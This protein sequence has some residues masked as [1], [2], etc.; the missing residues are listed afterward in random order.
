MHKAFVRKVLLCCLLGTARTVSAQQG[1][2]TLDA[3]LPAHL[4]RCVT[5]DQ[6]RM[7]YLHAN[8]ALG[9]NEMRGLNVAVVLRTRTSSEP[10]PPDG[11]LVELTATHW[12]RPLGMRQLRIK[13]EDCAG[14]PRA[15][16]DV[17]ARMSYEASARDVGRLLMLPP[18]RLLV[19]PTATDASALEDYVA[20]GVGAGVVGGL[21]PSAAFGLQLQAATT[22]QP[23]SLRLRLSMLWPQR[24]ALF[25]GSITGYSVDLALEMCVGFRLLNEKLALRACVGPRPG[26]EFARGQDFSTHNE[27]LAKPFL[28]FGLAPEVSLRLASA[29][30]LQLG[31]GLAL[32]LVRPRM[33][34]GLDSERRSLKLTD[35]AAVRSELIAS[36]VQIL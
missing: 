12:G 2:V 10:P 36:V 34:L 3:Q 6:L 21:L 13:P 27:L 9:V 32:G 25:D 20:L 28:Y 24:H 16:G 30:W 19:Q 8:A 26:V 11:A 17:V 35:P 7:G 5:A 4:Q 33:R 18:P 31:G 22:N 15:L 29:T 14:L 23:V 1:G